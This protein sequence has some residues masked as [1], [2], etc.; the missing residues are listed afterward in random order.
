MTKTFRLSS[1]PEEVAK[2]ADSAGENTVLP[3]AATEPDMAV[4]I[5]DEE[6]N[7]R[8]GSVAPLAVGLKRRARLNLTCHVT[9]GSGGAQDAQAALT[10]RSPSTQIKA[11]AAYV[12]RLKGNQR[13]KNPGMT[14]LV[15]AWTTDLFLQP[16]RDLQEGK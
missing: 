3:L 2:F 10:L 13:K 15:V 16:S 11:A 8:L 6:T 5:V 9:K 1:T 4:V 14:I 12:H 7:A